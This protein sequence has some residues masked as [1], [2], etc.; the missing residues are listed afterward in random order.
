MLLSLAALLTLRI[1]FFHIAGTESQKHR[2]LVLGSG[3]N[4]ARIDHL[5]ESEPEQLG[6]NVV[7]YVR[8]EDGNNIID[9]EN[10]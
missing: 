7:K 10:R 1:V 5:M 8:L 2:V 6:F 3:M 4:A 9:D